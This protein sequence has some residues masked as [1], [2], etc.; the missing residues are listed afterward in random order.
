MNH[1]EV[2][3]LEASNMVL[4]RPRRPMIFAIMSARTESTCLQ[5]SSGSIIIMSAPASKHLSALLIRRS[6]SSTNSADDKKKDKGH[7]ITIAVF[8]VG[9]EFNDCHNKYRAEVHNSWFPILSSITQQQVRVQLPH[10]IP[11]KLQTWISQAG[12]P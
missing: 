2:L 9:A 5:T 8:S 6:T 7:V 4:S 3:G 1:S 12:K 10:N 11:I